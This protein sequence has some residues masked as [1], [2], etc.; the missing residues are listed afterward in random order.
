MLTGAQQTDYSLELQKRPSGVTIRLWKLY[1]QTTLAMALVW[2][3]N[4]S[5]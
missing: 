3:N 4:L 5:Q 2:M 1:Q